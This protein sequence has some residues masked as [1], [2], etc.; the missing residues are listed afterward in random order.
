MGLFGAA[1]TKLDG[2]PRSSAAASDLALRESSTLGLNG[3]FITVQELEAEQLRLSTEQSKLASEQLT[4]SSRASLAVRASMN[5]AEEPLDG[6]VPRLITENNKLPAVNDE[7]S[8]DEGGANN[9]YTS[10]MAMPP[11]ANSEG[12]CPEV[13]ADMG[14]VIV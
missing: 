2:T 3:A 14:C 7:D 13:C 1:G 4:L 5:T 8:Y 11:A 12:N 6:G 9:Y 10:S